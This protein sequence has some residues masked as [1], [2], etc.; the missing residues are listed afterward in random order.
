LKLFR[1]TF[2]AYV[3]SKLEKIVAPL[4][5]ITGKD[6]DKIGADVL[7][8][9]FDFLSYMQRTTVTIFGTRE[10]L[11]NAVNQVNIFTRA[12]DDVSM[13][14][15]LTP[16]L[17]QGQI[18]LSRVQGAKLFTMYLTRQVHKIMTQSQNYQN[19]EVEQDANEKLDKL[20]RVLRSLCA[21]SQENSQTFI[22]HMTQLLANRLLSTTPN[23]D[24]EMNLI[25]KLRVAKFNAL[26]QQMEE[27]IKDLNVVKDIKKNDDS[28]TTLN[29]KIA[30][31]NKLPAEYL[32]SSLMAMQGHSHSHDQHQHGQ[33][34]SHS[35]EHQTGHEHQQKNVTKSNTNDKM[36]IDSAVSSMIPE[37]VLPPEVASTLSQ[38]KEQFQGDESA[39]KKLMVLP[40]LGECEMTYESK[41]KKYNLIVPTSVMIVLCCFEDKDQLTGQE[42]QL[43]T[44]LPGRL[45]M[46]TLYT[47]TDG[48]VKFLLREPSTA[49]IAPTNVFKLNEEFA[50]KTKRVKI[51]LI[52]VP[53]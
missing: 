32:M 3:K 26:A 52:Q 19:N 23:L 28:K 48:P 6:L 22:K 1:S 13:K 18:Y 39:N 17:G 40:H 25:F 16:R 33:T 10:G 42:L 51:Q 47:L 46:Q 30:S 27:M 34:E 11:D 12:T 14:F 53:K 24:F 2:Y 37:F 7:Q 45:L 43:Q 50:S 44:N 41:N 38:F 8:T 15:L 29:L 4:E 49:P 21:T 9:L 36:D 35:H 20:V 5:N 31:S